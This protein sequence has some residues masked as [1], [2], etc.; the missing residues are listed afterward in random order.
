MAEGRSS[1]APVREHLV[2]LLEGGGAHATF[3][4]AV[5]DL[6]AG[7]RGER[8]AGLPYSP[9]ELLEHMRLAQWDIVE[10]SR[11]PGHDS[12]PWPGGYWPADPRPPDGR[13]WQRSI[14]VFERDRRQ[15]IE[16][17]RDPGRDLREPL[18]WGDGQTLLREALLVA[19]HTAYH[20][21]QL[22]V[23]RRLL[24]AWEE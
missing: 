15:M 16:F 19:D 9:W 3:G 23:V 13:A 14:R 18:N 22:I 17:V 10:F 24:G 21:G 1:D 6:P 8:P 12:P 20:L 7:L 11:G 4:E 2:D 5:A